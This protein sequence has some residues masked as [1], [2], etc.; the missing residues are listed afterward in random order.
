MLYWHTVY[1]LH[2][3]S[4]GYDPGDEYSEEIAKP[5]QSQQVESPNT[6]GCI[7]KFPDWV[8]N[9][10]NNNRHSLGSNTNAYGG[11]TH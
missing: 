9:E 1:T 3:E 11:E 6:R 8:D 5:S 2:I 4:E 7:Q 10:I